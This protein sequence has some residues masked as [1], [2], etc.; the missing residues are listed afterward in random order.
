MRILNYGSMNIDYVY[1]VNEIV[2]P[3]ETI[4]ATGRA[5]YNGGKGLN[6]SIA[7]ARAGAEV[8]HAGVVGED[9]GML[10]EAL[11]KNGVNTDHVMRREGGSSHTVIQVNE[12]GQN[13]IIVFA[14]ANMR[15]SEN[16]QD[17]MLRSF[18][19]G[20]ALI[21]Q[22]ELYGSELMMKKAKEKG[23]CVIFNPSPVNENLQNYPLDRVDWF[24]MNELEGEAIT[25]KREPQEIL[26]AIQERYPTAGVVLTLGKDGAF[27]LRDGEI[28]FQPSFP[29]RAVD[30]T[31]A[32]DTFT[33]YF[34]A[35]L[36]S[37]AETAAMM[38]KA[39]RAASIAVG[40]KGAADSIPLACELE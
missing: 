14:G 11:G 27:C 12:Q 22:N 17:E 10:L 20:D 2:K 19:S 18:G 4:L 9:G 15:P 37:G 38:E 34:V 30:T 28:V 7:I 35:G 33:G 31:A 40:R 29:V 26:Q 8:Y 13:C 21:L 16:D 32:G 36:A 5:I 23:L 39:A 1:S 24:V 25:G 6:Q 3:G